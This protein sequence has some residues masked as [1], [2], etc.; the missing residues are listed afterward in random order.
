MHPSMELRTCG[1]GR[2]IKVGMDGGVL[3]SLFDLILIPSK[4][5]VFSNQAEILFYLQWPE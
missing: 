3:A 2:L 1:G 4:V 5:L